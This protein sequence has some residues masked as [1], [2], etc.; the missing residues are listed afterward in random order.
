[1]P[2]EAPNKVMVSWLNT[3]VKIHVWPDIWIVRAISLR[4]P[5][6]HSVCPS[7]CMLRDW[8]ASIHIVSCVTRSGNRPWWFRENVMVFK[9]YIYMLIRLP[10]LP[11][12]LLPLYRYSSVSEA[13][14]VFT[15]T[16]GIMVTESYVLI[17]NEHP[18]LLCF[19]PFTRQK[20]TLFIL[21]MFKVVLA[22]IS[23]WS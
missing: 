12:E 1:M 23:P 18:T 2:G 16:V 20:F 15:W 22:L 6:R 14:K 5:V 13:Q 7:A 19:L 3:V 11:A 9:D 17:F 4:N 10:K 8:H 21:K